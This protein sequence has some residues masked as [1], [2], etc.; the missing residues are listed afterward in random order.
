MIAAGSV[1]LN[2]TYD[3][4]KDL[5]ENQAALVQ[6]KSNFKKYDFENWIDAQ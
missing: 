5:P 4:F 1:V 6:L 3:Q 2:E